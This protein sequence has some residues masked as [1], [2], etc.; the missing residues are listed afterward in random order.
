MLLYKPYFDYKAISELYQSIFEMD[1]Q[2]KIGNVV[3]M[4]YHTISI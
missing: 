4:I 2:I 1:F 3:D